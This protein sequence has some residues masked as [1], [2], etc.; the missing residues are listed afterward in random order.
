[1]HKKEKLCVI[2]VLPVMISRRKKVPQQVLIFRPALYSKSRLLPPNPSELHV[3]SYQNSSRSSHTPSPSLHVSLG[4]SELTSLYNWVRISFGGGRIIVFLAYSITT[5]PISKNTL[6]TSEQII[7]MQYLLTNFER[8][9]TISFH[10]VRAIMS[11]LYRI[12]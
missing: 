10:C 2:Q 6:Y 12:P 11:L 9:V 5:I 7:V 3:C 4:V 8:E 1:M